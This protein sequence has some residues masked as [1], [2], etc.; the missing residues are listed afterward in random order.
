MAPTRTGHMKAQA[1]GNVKHMS[2][3][4]TRETE[5]HCAQCMTLHTPMQIWQLVKSGENSSMIGKPKESDIEVDWPTGSL[6]RDPSS[7]LMVNVCLTRSDCNS[8][9]LT[10]GLCAFVVFAMPPA[11]DTLDP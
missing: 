3:H 2:Q 11:R 6:T 8:Y 7:I 9:T 4:A 1:G 10:E 5:P